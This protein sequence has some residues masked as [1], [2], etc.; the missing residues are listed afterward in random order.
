MYL[1]E[2]CDVP[3]AEPLVIKYSEPRPDGFREYFTKVL[4]PICGQAYFDE[5][6]EDENAD[7]DSDG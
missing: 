7:E 1:C 6:K 3:F 2:T 4:C 5:I